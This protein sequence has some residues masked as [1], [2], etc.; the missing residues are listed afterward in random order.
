[1]IAPIRK[2]IDVPCDPATAFD[3]L[4]GQTS[5]WWPLDRNSVSAM[6]GRAAR[7]VTIEAR[8]GGRVYETGAD[9]ETIE[10]GSVRVFEPPRRLVLAWHIMTPQAQASEVEFRLRARDGGTTVE[11]EH[12]DWD[13][14]AEDAQA[15]RDSYDEGWVG[16]F[17]VAFC[18]A[19]AGAAA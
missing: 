3:L 15:S 17:E 10:W 12:R 5:A 7:A 1:M 13:R 14:L 8:A 6:S 18:D 16:V 4:V 9:G 11:L 2:S 19:C